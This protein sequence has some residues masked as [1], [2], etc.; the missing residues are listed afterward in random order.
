MHVAFLLNVPDERLLTVSRLA[1]ALPPSRA[2]SVLEQLPVPARTVC[3]EQMPRLAAV[4]VVQI[5]DPLRVA[6]AFATTHHQDAPAE[7]RP[8][9]LIAVSQRVPLLAHLSIP[10]Q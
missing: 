8:V 6:Q 2:A 3:V 4:P 10:I 7:V 1:A 9:A 5:M